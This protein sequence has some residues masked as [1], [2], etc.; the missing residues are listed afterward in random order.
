L[1]ATLV[2]APSS[3][4]TS[5]SRIQFEEIAGRA[6]LNFTT[7]SSPTPNKNQVETMVAGVALLDYDNDGYLDIYLVK[8]CT[9]WGYEDGAT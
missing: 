9:S 4:S 6:R 7:A 8:F 1:I 3:R 2:L 5:S